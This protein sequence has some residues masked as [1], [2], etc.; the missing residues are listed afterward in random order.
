VT[1][2]DAFFGKRTADA[3]LRGKQFTSAP[4]WTGT[5]SADYR[6]PL[7]FWG[8]SAFG[9]IAARYQSKVNTSAS[10]L[11]QAAQD[12]YALVNGRLGLGFKH[13][14]DISFVGTNLTDE[15]YYPVIFAAVVQAGSFNGYPGARRTLGFELRKRF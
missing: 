7:P 3:T 5:L 11:P 13:D 4:K 1:Y 2:A 10:L 14:F 15:V 9:G 6:Q 8:M 12:G